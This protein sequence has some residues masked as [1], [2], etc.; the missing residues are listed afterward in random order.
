VFEVHAIL[1]FLGG[2]P[3]LAIILNGFTSDVRLTSPASSIRNDSP[4]LSSPM[5]S[6]AINNHHLKT[7]ATPRFPISSAILSTAT[8]TLDEMMGSI[9]LNDESEIGDASK[10]RREEWKFGSVVVN[11]VSK[12]LATSFR[13]QSDFRKRLFVLWISLTAL[14]S[15]ISIRLGPVRTIGPGRHKLWSALYVIKA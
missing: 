14:M 8:C 9:R 12:P 2:V 13:Y 1:G 6:V 7:S 15:Q 3:S 10:R 4:K 11:I 5:T